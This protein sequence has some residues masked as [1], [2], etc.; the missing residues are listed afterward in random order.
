MSDERSHLP[1]CC[2]YCQSSELFSRRISSAGPPFYLMPGLG[3][4][5]SFAEMDV[6]ICASCG[7]TQLFAEPQACVNVKQNAAWKRIT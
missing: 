7:L 1:K 3:T 6:V 4:Y 5:L 2:P